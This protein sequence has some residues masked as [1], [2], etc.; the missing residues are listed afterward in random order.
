MRLLLVS[1]P[2]LSSVY[3]QLRPWALFLLPHIHCL[4]PAAACPERLP[5]EGVQNT[6]SNRVAACKHVEGP[7]VAG[8]CGVGTA[9]V[10]QAAAELRLHLATGQAGRC[11]PELLPSAGLHS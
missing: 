10:L 9:G 11:Y 4:Q 6:G 2:C 8:S 1:N 5:Q 3:I 7:H